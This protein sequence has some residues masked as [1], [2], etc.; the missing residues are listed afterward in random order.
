MK[1]TI[2]TFPRIKV[3]IQTL[4]RTKGELDKLTGEKLPARVK[5][6]ITRIHEAA[7]SA[8]AKFEE[9]RQKLIR[10]FGEPVRFEPQPPKI[11]ED[12]KD[13]PRPPLRVVLTDPEDLKGPHMIDVPENK[14]P[15]FQAAAAKL[16]E[17]E[18]TLEFN[19]QPFLKLD[20][21]ELDNAPTSANLAALGW[22]FEDRG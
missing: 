22:M 11:G 7:V 1:M 2:Q 3:T 12:G 20:I 4:L 13:I 21:G 6:W 5:Y 15:E 14:Q 16:V 17:R 9:E 8:L 18:V 19:G 10:E